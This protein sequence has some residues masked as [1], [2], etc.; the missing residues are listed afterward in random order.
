MSFPLPVSFSLPVPTSRT[1]AA[2]GAC[3]AATLLL[4]TTPAICLA[5]LAW[6]VSLRRDPRWGRQVGAAAA[7]AVVASRVC[8]E[9]LALDALAWLWVAA[10]AQSVVWFGA[11]WGASP[12]PAPREGIFVR[13]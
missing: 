1:L 5:A 4:P 2:F 9:A 13:S 12:W 6:I 3:F 7:V 11:S 8:G 10:V